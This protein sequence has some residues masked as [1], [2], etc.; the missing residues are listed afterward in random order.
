MY[1][2][3]FMHIAKTAGSSVNTLFREHFGDRALLH[4]EGNNGGWVGNPDKY[5]FISGHV[6]LQDLEKGLG[7]SP[8]FAFTVLRE[9][10]EH[11][12]SHLNWI[13]LQVQQERFSEFIASY[14]EVGAISRALANL[15]IN[16]P[17]RIR[18]FLEAEG[19]NLNCLQYFDN[20]QARYFSGTIPTKKFGPSDFRAALSVFD[21][22]DH[23]GL[24][25]DLSA[26]INEVCGRLNIAR[27]DNTATENV[28]EYEKNVD[29]AAFKK[30][31]A[32]YIG[33]DAALFELAA[34]RLNREA[35]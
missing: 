6:R 17:D 27:P 19:I 30:I 10:V 8:S 12:R 5:D 7:K 22:F 32:P 16:D 34:V 24:S 25:S 4:A 33:F 11:L 9:P 35:A 29:Q 28:E 21:R 18:H 26:T 15:D 13:R 14:P 3:F 31:L 1:P 20:C 2:I 23:I